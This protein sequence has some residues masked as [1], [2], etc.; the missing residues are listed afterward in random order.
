MSEKPIHVVE[1][2]K[3]IRK[4]IWVIIIVT[5]L[6][7]GASGILSIYVI[8]PVYESS[9]QLLVNNSNGT[10]PNSLTPNDLR[11]SLD[12][13]ATYIEVITSPRI[14]DTVIQTLHL[15]LNAKQLKEQKIRVNTVKQSQ[16]ISIIVEDTDPLMATKIANVIASTFQAEIPKIMNVDNVQILAEAKSQ[17]HP[18]PV[19]PKPVLYIMVSFVLV[20]TLTMGSIFIIE[21]MNRTVKNETDVEDLLGLPVIGVIAQMEI[22]KK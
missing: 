9:T 8:T 3:I 4:R 6:I 16:V 7:T 20:L 14:L 1:L 13:I 10:L 18:K 2:V 17:T 11:F 19:R 21:M 22:A 5:L 12:I 15:N